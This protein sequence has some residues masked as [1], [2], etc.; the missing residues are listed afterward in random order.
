MSCVAVDAIRP[1]HGAQG[2]FKFGGVEFFKINITQKV[3]EKT[4]WDNRTSIYLLSSACAEFIA[5]IFLC[6]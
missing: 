5:D 2:W 1:A 3:G 4:A 6:P